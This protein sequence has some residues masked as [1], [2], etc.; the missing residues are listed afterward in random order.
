MQA[1]STR[2]AILSIGVAALVA[3]CGGSGSTPGTAPPVAVGH[4]GHVG[5]AQASA[6]N[7]VKF[8]GGGYVTGLIYH[9][10]SPNVLYARTDVG[11]AYR[12]NQAASSW[13][14]ITD[15]VGFGAGQ[16]DHC[17]ESMAVDTNNDQKLYMVAGCSG[18][19]GGS[20]R[21]RGAEASRSDGEAPRAGPLF[22]V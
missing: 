16:G 9:P 13:T 12:W 5:A 20:Q 17:I 14:P 18:K 8:G 1:F 7:S 21:G 6:W 4:D 2:S 15:G 19:G 22:F 11:G 3:A 10:T